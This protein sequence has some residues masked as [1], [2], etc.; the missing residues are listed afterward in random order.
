MASHHHN[1]HHTATTTSIGC[2]CSNCCSHHSA[3]PTPPSTDLLLQTILSHLLQQRQQQKSPQES[4]YQHMTHNQTHQNHH[5]HNQ[6]QSFHHQEQYPQAKLVLSSLISRIDALETSLQ[7]FSLSSATYNRYSSFSSCSLRDAAARVIQT[8][9]RVFLVRRSRTLRQL[10]ELALI[11]SSFNSLQLSV[12]KKNHLD[13][14]LVS[15]RAMDLLRKLDS[16]QGDDPMIRD[17]K[18]SISRDLDKFLEFVDAFAVRNEISCRGSKNVKLVRNDTVKSRFLRSNGGDFSKDQ[19]NIMKKLGDRA[20][21]TPGYSRVYKTEDEDVELEGFHQFIDEEKQENHRVYGNKNGVLVKKHVVSQPK[22]KKSVSFA[23]NGNVYRIF[24]NGNT[25]E[26]NPSRD[27]TSTDESVSSDDNGTILENIC[28]EVEG[29]GL[30]EVTEDGVEVYLENGGSLQSSDE[31]RNPRRSL[32]SEDTDEI[33]GDCIGQDGHF[34]FSAPLPVKME[35][36]ADLMKRKAVK[37]VT[38]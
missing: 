33:V 13:F 4:H 24:S 7:N 22:V 37:I 5:F 18:R 35:S 31:E 8:H 15:R 17:R 23:E 25:H 38:K 30:Y 3:P 11:K 34:V 14:L 6:N 12:S 29:K 19:V 26:P 20:E 28:P 36:R 32:R 9:F 21:M 10:K 2:C 1:H 27:G 16:I